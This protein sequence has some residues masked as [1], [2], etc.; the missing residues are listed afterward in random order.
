MLELQADMVSKIWESFNGLH[1]TVVSA[2]HDA[3]IEE[4]PLTPMAES[5][6]RSK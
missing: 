4:Q 6:T 1:L 2:F 5:N 3:R